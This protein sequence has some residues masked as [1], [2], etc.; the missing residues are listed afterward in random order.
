LLIS[1]EDYVSGVCLG[2]LSCFAVVFLD[3]VWGDPFAISIEIRIGVKQIKVGSILGFR[4]LSIVF[5]SQFAL[6]LE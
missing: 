5:M 1:G 3:R 6:E 4:Y 2:V